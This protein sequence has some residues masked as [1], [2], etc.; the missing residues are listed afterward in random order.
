[1]GMID[2]YWRLSMSDAFETAEWNGRRIKVKELSPDDRGRASSGNLIADEGR[3]ALQT[4]Y[5]LDY[6]INDEVKFRGKTYVIT[7]VKRDTYEALPQ[8]TAIIGAKLQD[9]TLELFE[10]NQQTRNLRTDTPVITISDGKATITCDTLGAEIYYTL[11]GT[12]PCSISPVY[13]DEIDVSGADV[14]YAL[15][16]HENRQ[17]SRIAK[18]SK[19]R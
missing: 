7:N 14:V 18:W 13:K 19:V 16:L 3:T 8:S 2:V 12:A 5:V 4:R 10:V 6:K 15:A 9:I 11:D 17:P 1:M